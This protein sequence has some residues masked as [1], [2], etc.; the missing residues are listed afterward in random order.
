MLGDLYKRQEFEIVRSY[1]MI[2]RFLFFL[3]V[4]LGLS[5]HCGLSCT[6]NKQQER[7][8]MNHSF[9]HGKNI[10]KANRS[11]SVKC[12][13]LEEK[14]PIREKSEVNF[15]ATLHAVPLSNLARISMRSTTRLE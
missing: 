3:S 1:H 10:V 4:G 12:L 15:P 13:E 8:K 11:D 9:F 6:A 14:M 7:N 2:L 5:N